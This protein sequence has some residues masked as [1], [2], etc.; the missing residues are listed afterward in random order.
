MN[1]AFKLYHTGF[2]FR[3]GRVRVLSVRV[4]L[5]VCAYKIAVGLPTDC[6]Q[7]AEIEEQSQCKC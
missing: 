4:F 7:G 6:G 3:G 1:V 5:W 2:E